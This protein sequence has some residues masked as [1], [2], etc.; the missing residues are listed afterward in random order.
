[1]RDFN[2]IELNGHNYKAFLHLDI[3]AFSFART[4]A[5]GERAGVYIITMGSK[6]YHLNYCD[7][8]WPCLDMLYELIP[9]LKETE[10]YVFGGGET[11]DSWYVEGLGMG[12][13][14]VLRET[15]REP[16]EKMK[17]KYSGLLK[18]KFLYNL[19]ADFVLEIL[20]SWPL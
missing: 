4:G 9:V 3:A 7:G 19:W 1:M 20:D 6:V 2:I 16:M 18:E 12:N 10:F 11:A 8:T 14:L 17:Q 13:Y 5:M 15:L